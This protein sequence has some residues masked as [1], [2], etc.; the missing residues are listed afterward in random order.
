M[1]AIKDMKMPKSCFDCS[2]CELPGSLCLCKVGHFTYE[3]KKEFT[4]KRHP[5][6]PL[7]EIKERKV[8]K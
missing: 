2:F 5:N 4:K 3:R 7:V 1:V 8:G 6:C